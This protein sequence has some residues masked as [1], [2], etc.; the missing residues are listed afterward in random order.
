MRD[1]LTVETTRKAETSYAPALLVIAFRL[2][3]T[4]QDHFDQSGGSEVECLYI[5]LL[6]IICLLVYRL[7]SCLLG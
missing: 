7:Y 2:D 5:W 4:G 3:V 1:L 6:L